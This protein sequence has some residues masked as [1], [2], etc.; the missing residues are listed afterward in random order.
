ME[1]GSPDVIIAVIDSGVDETHPAL[2]GGLLSRGPSDNWNFASDNPEPADDDGHGTFIAGILVGNGALGVRGLCPGCRVL[3]LKVPLYGEATSYARRRDAI[4]Y[5]LDKVPAG[6]HLIINLSWKTEGDIA[7]I[8]DAISTVTARNALVVASAGN[9]PS[10][11]NEPHYPSDYPEVTSV[12]AIG[13]NRRRA[14]YSFYG[15]QVDISAPGGDVEDPQGGIR[16]A[17]PNN[18]ITTGWGTSFAAPHVAGIAALIVSAGLSL[19][20]P[21]IRLAMESSA[22]PLQDVGMGHGLVDG[23]AALRSLVIQPNDGS[24]QVINSADLATLV[25]RFGLL[26]YTARLIVAR[27]PFASIEQI[28]GI[29]GLTE[30]QYATIEKSH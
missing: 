9:S 23:G 27:R 17:A 1:R 28:H 18:S 29:S 7:L 2:Q 16:S 4:L 19:T 12:A 30:V 14:D 5:A 21:A 25:N 24:L 13:P 6:K 3:P 26:P 20:T 22:T 10:R 8:R 11:E 15:D